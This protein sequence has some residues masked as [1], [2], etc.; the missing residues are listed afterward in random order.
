MH[1]AV[2]SPEE[3]PAFSSTALSLA[4]PSTVLSIDVI[5]SMDSSWNDDL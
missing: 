2:A 5:V 3:K 4:A 1:H